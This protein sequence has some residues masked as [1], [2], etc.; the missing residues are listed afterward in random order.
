MSQLQQLP[1]NNLNKYDFYE[2]GRPLTFAGTDYRS[3]T[4][5]GHQFYF[6]KEVPTGVGVGNVRDVNT[7]EKR[8]EAIRNVSETTE[9]FP[10]KVS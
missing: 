2:Y 7:I 1:P 4:T 5:R 3:A 10:F 9:A 8:T 6:P